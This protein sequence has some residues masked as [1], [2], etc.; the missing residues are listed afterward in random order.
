[1][2][3]FSIEERSH[4]SSPLTL[5]LC[6]SY[7]AHTAASSALNP[8]FT[9][10]NIPPPLAGHNEPTKLFECHAWQLF[11]RAV[12]AR[13]QH[14]TQISPYKDKHCNLAPAGMDFYLQNAEMEIEVAFHCAFELLTK[15]DGY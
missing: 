10:F 2:Q 3:S 8:T 7:C 1:L 14:N 4:S 11:G 5:S 13:T 12:R 6:V 15:V 9:Q